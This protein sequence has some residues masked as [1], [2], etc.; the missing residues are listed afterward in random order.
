MSSALQCAPASCN[1]R[2]VVLPD[3]YHLLHLLQIE[4]LED[5]LDETAAAAVS[6]DDDTDDEEAVSS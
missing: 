1:L 2:T 5:D 6:A 3:F 4:V